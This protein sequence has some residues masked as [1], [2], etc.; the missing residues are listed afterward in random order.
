MEEPLTTSEANGM[1]SQISNKMIAK[2]NIKSTKRGYPIKK[3]RR[4]TIKSQKAAVDKQPKTQELMDMKDEAYKPLS[5][6]VSM[7]IHLPGKLVSYYLII[8][9]S[10]PKRL[11]IMLFH[12]NSTQNVVGT[13]INE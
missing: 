11:G 7:I 1:G 12:L 4:R 5:L 8:K 3:Q 2:N 6:L 10:V 9:L 13:P